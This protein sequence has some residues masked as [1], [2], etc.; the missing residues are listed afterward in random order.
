MYAS[1]FILSVARVR[2]ALERALALETLRRS[3]RALRIADDAIA[4]LDDVGELLSVAL[5][6]VSL[7]GLEPADGDDAVEA[8]LAARFADGFDANL[9]AD[10]VERARE[11]GRIDEVG[12][13]VL[14][15]IDETA[16]G[17]RNW[18]L[19]AELLVESLEAVVDGF[20]RVHRR[21]TIDASDRVETAFWTVAER[22][23]ALSEALS[24]ALA[25]GRFTRRT[26]RRDTSLLLEGAGQL[27]TAVAGGD[28]A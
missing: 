5:P 1:S 8:I 15:P 11:T 21:A 26:V 17:A 22:L 10:T 6:A 4:A 28:D 16:S 24:E 23:V 12:T 14:V 20:R 2:T 13:D 19:L 7:P 27:A 25:V 3:D 9:A 18:W